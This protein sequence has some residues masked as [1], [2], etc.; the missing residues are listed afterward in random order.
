MDM[1]LFNSLNQRISNWITSKAKQGLEPLTITGASCEQWA[2][3]QKL[4]LESK[5][6]TT[7]SMTYLLVLPTV[8]E[9]EHIYDSIKNN[10]ASH[11]TLYFPGLETSP[12]G[13]ILPSERNLYRRFHT[14]DTILTNQ[15]PL[16]IVLTL[17]ALNL[18][19]PSKDFF[20]EASLDIEVS[21]ICSP[22]SLAKKLV[23]LGYNSATTVEEPGSFCQKGE[24]FD[25]YPISSQPKRIH[26]FDDMIEEIFAIDMSTGKTKRDTSY[27][28]IRIAPSPNILSQ[29][30]YVT[31]LRENISRPS[32]GMREKF[33]KRK[34]VFDR[35]SDGNLFNDYPAYL[36]LFFKDTIS[37][38]DLFNIENT[39]LC[40][41]NE[42]SLSTSN[43]ELNDYLREDYQEQKETTLLPSLEGLY[44]IT[45]IQEIS[46]NYKTIKINDIDILTTLDD[47][48]SHKVN[49]DLVAAKSF[50]NKSINPVGTKPEIIKRTFE[51]FK[52]NFMS[53][54]NILICTK[55]KSSIDEINNLFDILDFPR[56][57]RDRI[58]FLNF[59]INIGFYYSTEKTLIL[60]DSDIFA[61][62]INKIKAQR[63][64]LDL[65][66]EQ[67]ATL[68]KGDYVIHN[69]HGMG[70]YQGLES[71]D[72]GGTLT[73]YLVILY[74]GNDKVYVPVYKMNLIQKH[75]DA[76]ATLTTDTLRSNKFKNLKDRAKVSAK[77]LAFDLLKLQAERQS[78]DAFAFSEPDH[79]YNDFELSF[80]FEETP[81]QKY[82]IESV[83]KSMMKPV[84]MDHLVCGDVGFGKT[85]VAMRAAYKAVL[86][87]KQVG[88][89][90]PTTILA[91]QH[92]NT[93]VK[94]FKDFPVNIEFISRFRTASQVKQVLEDLSLGKVDIIIGTHK[95][96][97]N[98]VKYLD[99]GLVVVDEEQ[100]F[101]VGHKEKLKLLKSSVDFLTL[102]ATPIPRTLQLSFLGL[103][104][105]TLIK[106]APP[107]RQSIKSY[108]IK[109]DDKTIQ[110]AIRKELSRG[111]QVF[112]VHNRVQDIEQYTADI[113]ELVPEAKIVYAHGQ[114]PEKE[115]E[116]RINSFYKGSFQIL[117]A[118]TIIESGIDI[119]NANTIIIDRADRFGLAQLHQLRGRIGRSDRKAYAY[120]VIPADRNV[121]SIAEKRLKALQTYADIGSGF[122]IATTDMEIRGAG[123]IL[124]ATQS[125]HIEAVGLELYMELLKEAIGELR[126]EKRILKKDIE[127]NTPF[128]SYIPN[129]YLT[130]S[131]ERLKNYKR[132]SNC[133]ELSSLESIKEEFFDVYGAH[134]EPLKNLFMVLETRII[135]QELGLKS[136]QIAGTSIILNFDKTVLEQDEKLR[137]QVINFFIS[138]PKLYQFTPDYKVIYS[139]KLAVTGQSLVEFAQ[140]VSVLVDL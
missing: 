9:A 51:F 13:G 119:P 11:Q 129:T 75:A 63:Q 94:R 56:P 29:K 43:L 85:E 116:S 111:G 76:T 58:H 21:D 100:R 114:L 118:T 74:K 2:T 55:S 73:D 18:K 10:I 109:K 45:T 67:L 104:E 46:Q 139:E 123:D 12:Y 92:Y 72:I 82:A 44:N 64:D 38:I 20:L 134:P 32:P 39:V 136:I 54:G 3:I 61:T 117:I 35:L 84:P 41:F 99:L 36:P 25:I 105:M 23:E 68:K 49:L 5:P 86:D 53:T 62:K 28:K 90:V 19:L 91:L 8:E 106:T 102:S 52:E 16:I 135:L 115:L 22:I 130:D 7:S 125:G 48:T 40:L 1:Q 107:R 93:F 124:G 89:L 140:K 15:K 81:D 80:P 26:Y 128:P 42:M 133:V 96:L 132:L 31:T 27:E 78:S 95:L 121:S 50:I 6:S 103:R 113:S 88:V 24:I 137:S 83:L 14:I 101:G 110:S 79:N 4:I 65:F 98:N 60:S 71:L 69:E 70:E 122:N 37:L 33:E 127:I 138:K 34:N 97:S 131:G 126:G 17:E 120:F 108:L 112:I 57:I 77:K 47:T 87:K 59:K 66:A 30:K